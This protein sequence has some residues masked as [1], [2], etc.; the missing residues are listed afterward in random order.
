MKLFCINL[1]RSVDRREQFDYNWVN[2]LNF[3]IQYFDA[4][5]KYSISDTQLEH[6]R[7]SL[8]KLSFSPYGTFYNHRYSLR[9]IVACSMS[10]YA[11]LRSIIHEIDD[12]GVVIFEDDVIPLSGADKLIQR[13]TLARRHLPQVEAIICGAF[14]EP[15]WMYGLQVLDKSLLGEKIYW[16]ESVHTIPIK[17]SGAALVKISPPGTF[18]TWYNNKGVSRMIDLIEGRTFLS[19]D[20]LYAAFAQQGILAILTPGLGY[21]PSSNTSFISDF[22]DTIQYAN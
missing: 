17:G 1:K 6:A 11:L 12:D 3:D 16:N 7:I 18:F 21:H 5:D 20:V 8:D 4:I 14:P 22:S 2:G 15:R 9:G 10:H 19:V 13:I